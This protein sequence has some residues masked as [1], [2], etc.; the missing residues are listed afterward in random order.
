MLALGLLQNRAALVPH[1]AGYGVFG[2]KI[3]AARV[4]LAGQVKSSLTGTQG[5]HRIIA[6]RLGRGHRAF[7]G[8][9]ACFQTGLHLLGLQPQGLVAGLELLHLHE[10]LALVYDNKLTALGHDVAVGDVP[11]GHPAVHTAADGDHVGHHSRVIFR[12]VPLAV[13]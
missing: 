1:P 13:N 10:G 6:M 3:F 9:P 4:I 7:S 11:L 12:D 8:A 2:N 5:R